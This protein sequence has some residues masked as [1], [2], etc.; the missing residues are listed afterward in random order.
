VGAFAECEFPTKRRITE[1]VVNGITVPCKK[2]IIEGVPI[3]Y[4]DQCPHCFISEDGHSLTIQ[5]T[6]NQAR[7]YRVGEE[8]PLHY[9]SSMVDQLENI[10][11]VFDLLN[12]D[13]VALVNWSGT[14]ERDI[15]AKTVTKTA[16]EVK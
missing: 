6:P 9:Y 3:G 5:E 16:V 12:T 15:K 13:D 7:V 1:E 14:D 11:R 2:D 8:M 10:K 4:L